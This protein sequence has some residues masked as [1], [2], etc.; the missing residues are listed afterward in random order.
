MAKVWEASRHTGSDLLMLLAIAD[1]ADDNGNAYPS[2]STL[3]AKCRMQPRNARYCLATLVDS[4]ELKIHTNTGPK[5]TNRYGLV[6]DAMGRQPSAGVQSVAGVQGS[7]GVQ[8][9]AGVQP[10]AATP[11]TDCREPLQRSAAEPSLNHHEPPTLRV[12][13]SGEGQKKEGQD[14]FEQF[15]SHYPRKT[16]KEDAR[17]A[18]KALKATPSLLPTILAGLAKWKQHERWTKDAGRYI[19]HPGPWLRGRMW[20]DEEVCGS[21]RG[22]APDVVPQWCTQAGFDNVDDAHNRMCWEHNA[23]QF[24]D[25]HRNCA[26]E[27]A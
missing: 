3:A 23:H 7:A 20:D 27:P 2:V 25:G 19:K 22:G 5:G 21:L 4:G 6:F 10:S 12:K 8:R 14:L 1:F 17:R 11:A 16:G 26:E 9:L 18:F 24:R 15:W 13:G